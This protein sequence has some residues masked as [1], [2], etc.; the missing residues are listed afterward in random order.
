M[1]TVRVLFVAVVFAG[2]VG[3]G[4]LAAPTDQAPGWVQVLDRI[5]NVEKKVDGTVNKGPTPDPTGGAVP[6]VS[7]ILS[8]VG[9]AWYTLRKLGG[10]VPVEVHQEA[11]SGLAT[12]TPAEKPKA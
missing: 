8:V 4:A 11:I 9:L 7:G 2:L 3:C 12:S 6:V 5:T 1:R 10:S